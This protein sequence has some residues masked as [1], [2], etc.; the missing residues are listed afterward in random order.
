MLTSDLFDVLVLGGGPAGCAAAIELARGGLS[1]LVVERS[2]YS[3][4]R[5]G[6]TLHPDVAPWLDRLGLWELFATVP[7][8]EAPGIV[9]LW[10]GSVPAETDFL[11]HPFGPGWH[12]DRR[13]FNA[14]IAE[15]ARR[16]GATVLVGT[17][18]RTC[19]ADAAGIWAIGIET[20]KGRGV[21]RGQ[22]A[23]DATGR[24]AWFI[25]RQG[26]RPV[27]KDHLVGVVAYFDPPGPL[28]LRLFLEAVPDGWWYAAPLPDRRV[29]AAFMTDHD[30]LPRDAAGLATFWARQLEA[31]RL[32]AIL[33]PPLPAS[34]PLR[35]VAA[36]SMWAVTVAGPRWVA[37]GD[38]AM[39][40]DPLAGQGIHQ[41]LASGWHAAR[42]VIAARDGIP[43]AAE[44]YQASLESAFHAYWAERNQRYASVEYWPSYPFWRR[45]ALG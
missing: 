5:V 7:C 3:G 2:D 34:T 6:D 11:F 27:V 13:R 9:S 16:A 40:H 35:V 45:R 23:I 19:Q 38:A 28:D 20:A 31:T 17:A 39:T 1:T 30:L 37:A 21:L 25:R 44:E 29:L 8:L 22:W 18:L 41:A 43:N 12:L 4:A 14:M 32:I 15:A 10:G 33:V 42:A 36:N 26:V 24:A